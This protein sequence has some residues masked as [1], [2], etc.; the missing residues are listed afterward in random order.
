MDGKSAPPGLPFAPLGKG[1]APC[2]R[3]SV[4]IRQLCELVEKTIN[5]IERDHGVAISS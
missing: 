2:R 1:R 5:A 4:L 3:E